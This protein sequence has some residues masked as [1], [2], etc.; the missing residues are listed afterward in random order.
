M[1]LRYFLTPILILSLY[2]G[3]GSSSSSPGASN[4][5][6]DAG[7]ENADCAAWPLPKLFPLIGPF[8]FGNDPGPCT[9]T[10]AGVQYDFSY[11][12]ENVLTEMANSDRSDVTTYEYAQGLLVRETRREHEDI[13][14]TTYDYAEG[15]VSTLTTDPDGVGVAYEY[16]LDDLGYVQTAKLLN[17]VLSASQPTH[18]LYQY[19]GCNIGRRIAFDRDDAANL[20]D[21]ADYSYDSQGHLIERKNAVSDEIFDYSCW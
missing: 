10:A 17:P 20:D 21:T 11:N 12:S 9:L 5:G 16:L 2:C 6:A 14:T 13:S 1:R 3:C 15:K 8:F 7:S 19:D 4:F 18:Y